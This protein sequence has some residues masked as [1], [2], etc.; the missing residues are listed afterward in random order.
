MQNDPALRAEL[1]RVARDW[2][3]RI[4]LGDASGPGETDAARAQTMAE[5]ERW[6]SEDPAHAVAFDRMARVLETSDVLIRGQVVAG[7]RLK[8]ASFPKRYPILTGA[9]AATLVAAGSFS[10]YRLGASNDSFFGM[11]AADGGS[12]A[13]TVYVTMA[14]QKR[15]YVLAD[16][17]SLFLDG[18]SRV[19]VEYSAEARKLRLERG[20]ARFTVTHDAA[21]AFSVDAGEGRVIAHGTIFEVALTRHGVHVALMRGSIEV[22]NFAKAATASSS[23]KSRF[24]VPG[25]QLDLTPTDPLP[26]PTDIVPGDLDWADGRLALRDASL[27]DAV[28]Q[29]NRFNSRRIILA[30]PSLRTLR[31]SGGFDARAPDAFARATAQALGLKLVEQVDGTLL[32][33]TG[34]NLAAR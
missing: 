31:I 16:G 9:I 21:R 4:Q 20:R 34:D 6:R 19:S 30:D 28:E 29:I 26:A 8:R 14:G 23:A 22:Q 17:S 25:Q 32:L 11:H 12:A 33:S 1:D 2:A 7:S 15:T 10:V 3:V 24:L 18:D 13:S 27:G 5:F